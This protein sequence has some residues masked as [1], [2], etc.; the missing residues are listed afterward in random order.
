LLA[1]RY[2]STSSKASHRRWRHTFKQIAERSGITEKIHDA[3]TGHAAPTEGRKYGAPTVEDMA[4]ALQKFPR[5]I[6]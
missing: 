6:P 5:Y 2:S 3:I 1:D 4:E